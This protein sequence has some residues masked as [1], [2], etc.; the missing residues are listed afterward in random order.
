M[1]FQKMSIVGCAAAL[2]QRITRHIIDR[3]RY[4]RSST[5]S[6]MRCPPGQHILPGILFTHFPLHPLDFFVGF[7]L[8]KLLFQ[9]VHG[10]RNVP[11]A[12]S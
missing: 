3:P 12:P 5:I 1:A 11:A 10:F 6:V 9:W 4:Y 7:P 8:G 2:G